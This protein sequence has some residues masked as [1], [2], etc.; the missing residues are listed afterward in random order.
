MNEHIL[1]ANHVEGILASGE[2]RRLPR[3]QRLVPQVPESLTAVQRHQR[4]QIHRSVDSVDV[5]FAQIERA[6]QHLGEPR[7][8]R[9][10]NFQAHRF[11]QDALAQR[12]LD[13]LKQVLRFI[14]VDDQVGVARDA[15]YGVGQHAEAA[16]QIAEMCGD[17]LLEQ[18]VAQSLEWPRSGQRD[19]AIEQRR[20]LDD[21]VELLPRIRVLDQQDDVQ[22]LVVDVRERMAGIDRQRCEDRIDLPCE[23]PVEVFALRRLERIERDALNAGR[24]QARHDL[25]VEQPVLLGDE[26]VHARLDPREL[27]H[28]TET[29][30]AVVL[31]LDARV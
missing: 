7:V 4:R 8:A 1:I 24:G 25:R 30:G 20:D 9:R 12:L 10:Q 3:E 15:K 13:R 14:F 16:E 31:R 27:L 19:D 17:D 2:R 23:Q 18:D 5:R 21:A 22:A 26:R 29:V 28:G 6:H 11:A